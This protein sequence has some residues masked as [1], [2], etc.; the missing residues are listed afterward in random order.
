MKGIVNIKNSQLLKINNFDTK[1][2]RNSTKNEINPRLSYQKFEK[3]SKKV[4]NL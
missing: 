3:V 1:L 4:N 2:N